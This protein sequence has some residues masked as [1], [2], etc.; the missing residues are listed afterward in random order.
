MRKLKKTNA[1]LISIIHQLKAE[2]RSRDVS[3]WR[4][5][6]KRLEKPHRNWATVNVSHISRHA[7]K[8]DTIVIPGKLLGAGYIR[9]PVTVAAFQSSEN[10]K[11]KIKSAGGKVISIKELIKLK[12]KGTGIRIFSK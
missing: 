8:N 2:S 10:A 11:E 1:E 7:K 9:I 3:L 5:L 4:D 6:A 12:P